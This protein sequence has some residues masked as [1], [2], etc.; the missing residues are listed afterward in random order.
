[1][2]ASPIQ[3]SRS[4]AAVFTPLRQRG[5]VE[6][7]SARV[8]AAVDTGLLIA[9]QRLPNEAELAAALGVSV[10]TTREALARLRAR[11][12]VVT[13]RGRNGGSFIADGARGSLDRARERLR[14]LTKV[15]LSDIGLHYEA[16]GS[17][18]AR[19]AA[20]RASA[21][22]LVGIRSFLRTESDD[23]ADWRLVDSEFVLEVAAVA[24]TAR[25]TRALLELQ[26]EIGTIA[27]LPYVN[28]DFREQSVISRES[29]AAAIESHDADA[30]DRAMRGLIAIVVDDLLIQ[31]AEYA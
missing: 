31:R 12:V 3:P 14:R 25:L 21:T 4:A 19:V 16:I 26:A 11:D 30:A 5:L 6:E 9:G 28:R 17:T 24:R 23:P 2:S 13:T 22:D 29:V 8:E 18:A 7:I 1:M 10:V 20:R 15:E 27:L